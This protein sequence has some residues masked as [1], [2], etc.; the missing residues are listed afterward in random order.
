MRACGVWALPQTGCL[1][2]CCRGDTVMVTAPVLPLSVT[3]GDTRCSGLHWAHVSQGIHVCLCELRIGI[4]CFFIHASHKSFLFWKSHIFA[5]N[6]G[7]GVCVCV[8]LHWGDVF[9]FS[10]VLPFLLF[11]RPPLPQTVA[12][13]GAGSSRLRSHHILY[14][15]QRP[16]FLNGPEGITGWGWIP[17]AQRRIGCSKGL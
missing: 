14:V 8:C 17:D 9:R 10:E 3:R 5:Y 15:Q 4:L 2:P 16:I 6:V 12:L 1:K 13:W 11:K 7:V